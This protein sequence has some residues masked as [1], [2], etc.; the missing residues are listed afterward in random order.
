[1]SN[2]KVT[3]NRP[4]VGIIALGCMGISLGLYFFGSQTG[5]ATV[6]SEGIGPAF[7]RVGVLM[8]ALW[9]ALPPKGQEAAW[10]KVTPG[11][12]VGLF[13]A[14]LAVVRLRWMAI[15]LVIGAAIVAVL[16]RP[17]AR[18]RPPRN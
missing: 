17:R 9:L 16:F 4:L 1:M 3:I 11:T 12:L 14:I 10:A 15:P 7:F 13:L 18:Y 8:A 5:E 6:A 2:G